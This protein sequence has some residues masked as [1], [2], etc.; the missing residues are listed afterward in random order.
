MGAALPA[1]RAY[2]VF[3]GTLTGSTGWLGAFDVAWAQENPIDLDLCTRCNACIRACPGAGDRR[4]LPGRPR[5]LQGPSRL[6]GRVRRRRRD[7]L[8]A[9]GRAR[10]PSAS[11]SCST[12]TDRRGSRQHQP[13]QGYFAPGRRSGRAGKAVTE[14]AHAHRRIREAEVLPLQGVDLRAQPLAQRPAA[15]NASTSARRCAIRAD[16]DHIA[17][18]PHLC[19]GCGACTTVC[20][21]GALTYAYPSVPDLG[22]RI[23]TLLATYASAGGRDACLLLH[24]EDGR[25]A[26]ARLRA[27]RQG[28]AGA[29]DPARG[30]PRRLRRARCLARGAR[31]GRVAG[32]RAGDRQR[33]AAVPRRARVPD[34]RRRHD[35]QCAGLP[36][37]AFPARR[38]RRARR[39]CGNGRPRSVRASPPRSRPRRKSARRRRSRSNISLRT[40]PFRNRCPVACRSPYGAIDDQQGHLHDV[41]RLCRVVPRSRD[42][43]QHREAAA[44][45]H[46]ERSASSAASAPRP[47]RNTR[48]PWC[49]GSISRRR[50]RRRGC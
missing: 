35:R 43:R 26:I 10:A 6:R 31:V 3:S 41:P 50:P 18:E 33:S 9:Q 45:L 29:R 19:V 20:P 21:S 25:D 44:A 16:G 22:A 17:V 47:A 15:R 14:L 13:P 2:P 12:C 48:S 32:R 46:R 30:P 8:R 40:R 38:R 28:P 49:R 37:R 5:P 42:P 7:R 11:I 36:G 34:A 1:E 24:A 23:K 39:A 27:P 4:E